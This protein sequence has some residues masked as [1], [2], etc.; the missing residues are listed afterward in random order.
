MRE[1]GNVFHEVWEETEFVA[2]VTNGEHGPH[3]A[4]TW[5]DYVRKLGIR[6]DTIVIPAGGFRQTE[7]NLERDNRIKMMI[8]SHKVPGSN[9]PGQGLEMQGTGTIVSIGPLFDEVKQK[10]PW[11][12][13]ALVVQVVK[14]IKHL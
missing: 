11:A 4:G 5:G 10:F 2:I 13:A 9:A 14:V 1:I 3:M 12:R 7:Q 8:A 6:G